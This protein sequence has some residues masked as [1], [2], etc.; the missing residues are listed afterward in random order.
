MNR[1]VTEEQTKMVQ[2]QV[3]RISQGNATRIPHETPSHIHL[4]AKGRQGCGATGTSA[5]RAAGVPA[6]LENNPKLPHKG[7]YAHMLQ[8]GISAARH[9]T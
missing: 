4:T 7:G 6:I 9:T 2:E 1:Q 8:P 5:P 3:N